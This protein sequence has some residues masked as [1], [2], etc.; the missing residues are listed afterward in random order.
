M[1]IRYPEFVE[2]PE[3]R[4]PVILLLDTSASMAGDPIMALNA[5][6]ANFKFD[7]E[8]D[9]LALLRV[10][11]AIITFGTEVSI[12]QDFT[13]ID[14]FTAPQLDAEGKTPLGH[15]LKTGLALLEKRKKIYR[16][17]GVQYYR[18][19]IFLITDGAPTDV[20]EQAATNIHQAEAENKLSF[21]TI[22]VEGADM[23]I[24]QQVAP[25]SRPP[26][27]LRDLAFDALFRWL[28]A[29]VRR[30]STGTVGGDMV[31]LPAV[32]SWAVA[33]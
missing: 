8:H 12:L 7:V 20:W 33:R 29:S 27:T 18:P 23:E 31:A 14:N 5:G 28:S 16:E 19:W 10:E 13:T 25:P 6:L 22:A 24:L 3:N 17:V 30:V 1:G 32:S 11:V 9:E 26:F 21:F 4:C 2:N 15:A